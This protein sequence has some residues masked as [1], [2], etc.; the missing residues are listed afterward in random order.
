MHKLIYDN[1]YWGVHKIIY[2]SHKYY[3]MTPQSKVKLGN[4]C[5]YRWIKYKNKKEVRMKGGT[6]LPKQLQLSC[7]LV[8]PWPTYSCC[9]QSFFINL[10]YLYYFYCSHSIII[11]KIE[12]QPGGTILCALTFSLSIFSVRLIGCNTLQVNLT[13]TNY[14]YKSLSACTSC[15]QRFQKLLPHQ[16]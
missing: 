3:L 2:M 4:R 1:I 10:K 8:G 15:C 16:I 12:P 5:I 11:T 7:I 6:R 9:A 13:F 14:A